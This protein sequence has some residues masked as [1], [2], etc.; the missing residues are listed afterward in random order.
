MLLNVKVA[1]QSEVRR[2]IEAHTLYAKGIRL[3]VAHL[4]AS[5]LLTPGTRLWKRD[6]KLEKVAKALGILF[7]LPKLGCFGVGLPLLVGEWTAIS[8]ALAL[9]FDG[10]N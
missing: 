8:F 1:R 5:C 3:S 2:M 9:A 10:P 6:A 4:V 7:K